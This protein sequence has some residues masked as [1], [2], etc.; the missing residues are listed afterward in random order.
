MSSFD[1]FWNAWP[2]NGSKGFEKY[3]RK[4]NRTGAEKVWDRD[5]LDDHAA[6]II[7]NVKQRSYYDREWR[8][9]E[10]DYLCG[11]LPY[12]NQKQWLDGG[13]NDTRDYRERVKKEVVAMAEDTGPET[14]RF[15]RSA[16]NIMLKVCFGHKRGWRPVP[17]DALLR[18]LAKKAEMVAFYEQCELEGL[19]PEDHDKANAEF[20]AGITQGLESVL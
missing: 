20:V 17:D 10:G 4:K 8:K 13:F 2:G 19:L 7:H 14:S 16:N 11:P 12:L 9:N 6:T 3:G 1:D 18:M 5:K 15:F